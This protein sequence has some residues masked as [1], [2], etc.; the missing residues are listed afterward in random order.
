MMGTVVPKRVMCYLYL[1]L[2]IGPHV[3]YDA[4][5]DIYPLPR[6]LVVLEQ[7]MKENW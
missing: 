5:Y 4:C 6:L 2:E 7:I 1:Q 3:M